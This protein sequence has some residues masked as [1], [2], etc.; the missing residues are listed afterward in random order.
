MAT[1]IMSLDP[2]TRFGWAVGCIGDETPL[3]NTK[4]FP[5]I[6]DEDRGPYFGEMRKWLVWMIDHHKPDFVVFERPIMP[7]P[8]FGMAQL[9]TLRLLYGNTCMIEEV[10]HDKG[11]PCFEEHLGTIKKSFTGKGTAKKAEMIEYARRVYGWRV[12]DDNQADACALW[13]LACLKTDSRLAKA[14]A[15]GALGAHASFKERRS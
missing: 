1:K 10:C 8:K 6:K 5:D 11:V 7:N 2:A 9:A 3:F 12:T 14:H 15:L 13:V 4:K